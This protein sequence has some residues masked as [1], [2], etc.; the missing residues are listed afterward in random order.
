M[1]TE[2]DELYPRPPNVSSLGQVRLFFSQ[3]KSLLAPSSVPDT[4]TA[5][6]FEVMGIF[7][8]ALW[9]HLFA[10]RLSTLRDLLCRVGPTSWPT[11]FL[12]VS[13]SLSPGQ[14]VPVRLPPAHFCIKYNC[15]VKER[16]RG[17]DTFSICAAAAAAI[18]I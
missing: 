10:C 15:L 9:S 6:M 18:S 1:N 14:S 16:G 8:Q 11:D 4:H 13:L 5:S 7:P 17:G 12:Q 2:D 3:T